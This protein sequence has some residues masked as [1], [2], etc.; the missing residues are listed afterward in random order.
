MLQPKFYTTGYTG[1]RIED[2]PLLLDRYEAVLADIKFS[3]YSRQPKWEQRNL[4]LILG[5]RLPPA[6][7]SSATG[8]IGRAESNS[9]ICRSEYKFN[10]LES[11]RGAVVRLRKRRRLPSRDGLRR[12]SQ[13]GLCGGRNK[14]LDEPSAPALL[15]NVA[16]NFGLSFLKL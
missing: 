2:L 6:S 10:E 9:C 5:K 8:L 11:E 4:R 13:K 12:A 7:F 16:K 1:K 14:Q 15:K 3:P